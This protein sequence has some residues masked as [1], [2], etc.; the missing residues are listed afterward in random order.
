MPQNEPFV[1]AVIDD[2]PNVRELLAV[3]GRRA[4]GIVLEAG[5]VAEGMRILREYPWDI[6]IIDRILPDGDGLELCGIATSAAGESHRYVIILS[7]VQSHEEKM[8]GFEAGAD[9]YIGKP[10]DASELAARLRA[11]R[12]TVTSQKSLMARLFILEQLSVIDGLTQVFNYRFFDA[13]IRRHFDLAVRH[14]RA[15]ALAMLD[16]DNFKKVNDTYGHPIGDRV[17]AEISTIIA[18]GIRSSDVLAR[19]GGEEFAIIL[20]ETTIEEAFM[21]AERLRVSIAAS[22]L[23][24]SNGPPRMTV[25]IG[26]AAIPS[27][28]LE[29]AVQLV[30]AADRALY[31]AKTEGRNCVRRHRPEGDDRRE[32][33]H[34]YPN[35]PHRPTLVR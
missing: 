1:I 27:P 10:I 35:V 20:P 8:R 5:S 12:R 19:Y 34:S 21:L 32:T 15:L 6:A 7:G 22:S 31:L 23:D 33:W 14:Q 9:E 11:V 30:E 26:V 29:T 28:P 24:L 16:L 2:D 13:E 3:I 18:Q 25:S 4:G 17:L